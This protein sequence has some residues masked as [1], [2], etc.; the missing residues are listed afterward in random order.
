MKAIVPKRPERQAPLTQQER[1]LHALNRFTFGPRP[2]E[3]EAVEKMGLQNWF[4]QQLQ[5]EK[6]DD[7]AFE[8]RMNEYPALRLSQD[9][10]M[11]RFP[12]QQM[13]RMADKRD[14]AIPRGK[15]EHALFADARYEYDQKQT[16]LKEQALNGA[17]PGQAAQPNQPQIGGDESGGRSRGS[18]GKGGEGSAAG[19]GGAECVGRS[20]WEPRRAA[21]PTRPGDEA[22]GTDGAPGVRHAGEHGHGWR[23]GR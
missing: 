9:E 20:R 22:A 14:V 3:V 13:I 8:Q 11:K 17:K 15:V 6:I 1:V 19:D 12:S 18:A 7:S 23:W 4:L 21:E 2:G 10:L 16:E 5:P